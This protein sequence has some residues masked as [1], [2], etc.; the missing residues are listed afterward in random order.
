MPK[1]AVNSEI[2]DW[3]TPKDRGMFDPAFA[4]PNQGTG[5]DNADLSYLKGSIGSG[6]RDAM[7]PWGGPVEQ[8]QQIDALR[9]HMLEQGGDTFKASEFSRDR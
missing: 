1:P 9:R 8:W 5:K 3:K 2:N 7:W 4:S 6:D